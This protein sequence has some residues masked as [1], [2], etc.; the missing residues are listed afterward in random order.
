MLLAERMN[1]VRIYVAKSF[2]DDVMFKLGEAGMIHQTDIRESLKD[3]EGYVHP[4]ESSERLFKLSSILSRIEMLISSLKL[5]NETTAEKARVER[6]LSDKDLERLE[7]ESARIEEEHS[8]IVSQ[9]AEFEKEEGTQKTTRVSEL[10]GELDKLAAVSKVQL[11]I[12]REQ[13]EVA[14]KIE[15]AKTRVGDTSKTFV[16]EGWVPEKKMDDLERVVQEASSGFC[17]FVCLETKLPQGHEGEEAKLPPTLLRNPRIAYVYEKIATSFGVPNYYEVDPS[18]FMLFSFPIIFGLMFGDVGQGLVLL[19]LT[20]LL[21]MVKRRNVKTSEIFAYLI[22]GSPL[23]VMCS[24]SAIF[25]GFLY[26]EFFGF[27]LYNKDAAHYLPLVEEGFRA[28]TGISLSHTIQGASHSLE[29]AISSI[30]GLSIRIP[31]PF[32]P[33]EDPSTMLLLSIYV[34][35]VQISFGLILGLINEL[36]NRRF[37]QAVIGPGLWIWFYWSFAYLLVKYGSKVFSVIFER[38]DILGIFLVLPAFT[39]ILAQ[40]AI[41]KMDGFGHALESLIASIS[42]T[43]SYGRILAL[44]LAHGAFSRILLMFLELQGTLMMIVGF[45]MWAAFTFLLIMCFEFLLSFIHTL[46]LHW[47]EWFLKFYSGNGFQ[48]QPFAITRRFTIV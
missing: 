47:V 21:Y 19:I 2:I 28:A 30:L 42:N 16:I 11:L 44:A 26:G 27:E 1:K 10:N 40:V 38:M 20:L 7:E 3:L 18:V 34:A 8:R 22:Q 24:I 32:S 9:L 12:N 46:R 29:V 48:Y 17:A 37:K 35:I 43:I 41:H 13:V 4:I 25:F 31:F 33:F 14:K 39:M 23:L 6:F 5:E 15:E 45:V 36:M